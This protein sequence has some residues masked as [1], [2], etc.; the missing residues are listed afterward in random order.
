METQLLTWLSNMVKIQQYS[1]DIFEQKINALSFFCSGAN[2][3]MLKTLI[4]GG[5]VVD[6]MDN[7]KNTPLM[8]AIKYG[9]YKKVGQK[10]EEKLNTF[11]V[12]LSS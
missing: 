2:K 9:K 1:I 7:D 6:T 4:K 8:S 10:L 11:F 5:A 3:K 12:F